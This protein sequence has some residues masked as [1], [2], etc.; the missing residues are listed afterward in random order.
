M[1]LQENI[2][3][4]KQRIQSRPTNLV[5]DSKMMTNSTEFIVNVIS[6]LEL[7]L[8]KQIRVLSKK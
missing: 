6:E 8:N 4:L 3:R 2:D 7:A 5:E 1:K